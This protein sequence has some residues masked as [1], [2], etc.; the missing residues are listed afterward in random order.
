M[1]KHAGVVFTLLALA[2]WAVAASVWPTQ[3]I[4]HSGSASI[5]AVG[6]AQAASNSGRPGLSFSCDVN[7]KKCTC[8]GIWEGADCQAMKKN[9]DMTK[10]NFCTIL[11][12]Y[13]CSCTLAA[14]ATKRPNLGVRPTT[15]PTT[16][17][18]KPN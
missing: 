12:P 1:T 5:A 18:G 4:D 8:S 16:V 14:K 7:T 2:A 10:P 17:Q 15:P 9:C 6:A 11:P 13:E 3:H